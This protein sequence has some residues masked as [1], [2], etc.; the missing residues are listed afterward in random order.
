M[1]GWGS[2]LG[3]GWDDEPAWLYE[4]TWEWE[5]LPGQRYPG[6]PSR[7][8]RA[9]HVPVYEAAPDSGPD[10]AGSVAPPPPASWSGPEDQPPVRYGHT[11]VQDRGPLDGGE[12][13]PPPRVE[14]SWN[15]SAPMPERLPDSR[16]PRR[17]DGPPP[18]A[19]EQRRPAPPAAEPM[20]APRP[21]SPHGAGR[22]VSSF[23][24]TRPI[25][26]DVRP[27]F[28]DAPPPVQDMPAPFYGAAQPTLRDA[29]PRSERRDSAGTYGSARPVP[30]PASGGV[31]PP[32]WDA[33][34][35]Y[36]EARPFLY[37]DEGDGV[38]PRGAV[39]QVGPPR[40]RASSPHEP[41]ARGPVAPQPRPVAPPPAP[42]QRTDWDQAAR[43]PVV[44]PRRPVDQPESPWSGGGAPQPPVA[45][46]QPGRG[47]SYGVAA[48]QSPA[49]GMQP[50]S[51]APFGVAVPPRPVPP[52]TARPT[53]QPPS[54]G[55]QPGSGAPLGT[56]RP[57]PSA[58]GPQPG[59]GA[60]FGVAAPRQP[61][62]NAPSPQPGWAG[63]QRGPGDVAPQP[64]SGAPYRPP[65]PTSPHAS[66]GGQRASSPW[67]SPQAD[68]AATLAGPAATAPRPE[69]AWYA[70]PPAAVTDPR[71]VAPF[72]GRWDAAADE[73]VF[74]PADGP[75]T[76]PPAGVE[77]VTAPP[78]MDHGPAGAAADLDVDA[79]VSSAPPAW[80]WGQPVPAQP[81]SALPLSAQ[82]VSPQAVP[83]PSSAQPVSPHAGAAAPV[84][85]PGQAAA[86]APVSAPGQ[87]AATAP[88][89]AEPAAPPAPQP[90]PP[91]DGADAEGE[92]GLGWLLKQHGLGA[93]T[94]V[95][96]AEPAAAPAEEEPEAPADEPAAARP[97]SGAAPV[98]Q[99]WFAPVT[100]TTSETDTAEQDDADETATDVEPEAQDDSGRTEDEQR[101]GSPG[102]PDQ[103]D[104][105]PAD[106]AA[107]DDADLAAGDPASDH[108]AEEAAAEPTGEDSAEPDE[109]P[110]ATTEQPEVGET[111]QAGDSVEAAPE[112]KEPEDEPAPSLPTA[113]ARQPG[114]YDDHPPRRLADPEQ[115]LASY[116]W[117]LS[118]DTLREVVDDPEPLLA[119]RDRLTDKLEYAERDAV[120]ARLLS[121]R[122]VVS[123]VLDDLDFAVADGRAALGHA[124]AA[125]EL[126]PAATARAR[127][128]H[129]L[130]F[131]GEFAEADRLFEE[132]NSAELPRRLRAEMYELAGRSAFDQG[133]FLEAVNRFEQA[134]DLRRGDDD[135]MVA[136]IEL[137]LDTIT[138]RA[139]D[140]GWGPYPREVGEILGRT[141]DGADRP[142]DGYAQARP[143]SD[144]LAWVSRD[145]EG[146]WFAVDRRDRVI[147]AG[148][149][150]DVGP[151]RHGVAPVR[152]GG[153]WGAVDRH[154]RMVVQPKYRGFVTVL[155]G[156]RAVDGFT[157]EGLAVVDAGERL[158]VI[159]RGGQLLVAPV[160]AALEIHPT[161]FLI[162]DRAG[163]WGALDR[164]G[165]P[166]VEVRH[167]SA[168]DVTGEIDRV[169]A[170][171]R[172]V[173]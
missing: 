152:R 161:A 15:R 139:V 167:R 82:P 44:P 164:N 129:V 119:V 6:D 169:L 21:V 147:V 80:D 34:D 48:P 10:T 73:M 19:P 87:V 113:F 92:H 131:R 88:V 75:V 109:V 23:E 2:H 116:P 59:S 32:R 38:P 165:D 163:R 172:P 39:G 115:V 106:D 127:L 3:G 69:R 107:D 14:P 29:R 52:A 134:L 171:P 8:R 121:L 168:E 157:E 74:D 155:A 94:V 61:R 24:Q 58:A 118:P 62:W 65:A 27:Q 17:G 12:P 101:A 104:S 100:D 144:G 81:V 166:L 110:L 159:D 158:G 143:F 79:P 77:P 33:P 86:T 160:H 84:S 55:P 70:A 51:G 125:G 91:A 49:A 112:T 45:R 30:P 95:P 149:F 47:T 148:G 132:A 154:G 35:V 111:A 99:N 60:P 7:R 146:G 138:R 25:P 93:V 128:A 13:G 141:D 145:A 66:P 126:V 31:Q 68:P 83:L 117:R 64:E 36:R 98:K 124:E 76:A 120:R 122:A 1:N 97:V 140:A 54:T 85:A 56:A 105:T 28:R 71:G 123:R 20:A 89:S 5:P 42:G 72:E 130:R 53:Q 78:A 67:E 90:D 40:G 136:R 142:A 9:V 50:G 153:A 103:T 150:D 108:E 133:R 4:I 16:G 41:P 18:P 162:G 102:Q 57:Q 46:P 114:H 170:E 11:P 137:A 26:Q 135:A 151:F 37:D 22:P 156:G 173:L 43:G 63:P 96:E